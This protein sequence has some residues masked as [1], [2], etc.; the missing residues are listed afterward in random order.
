MAIIAVLADYLCSTLP[1]MEYISS[2]HLSIPRRKYEKTSFPLILAY[3]FSKKW[4]AEVSR[5]K[6]IRRKL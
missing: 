2:T 4:T 1:N 3:L 5:R 6:K